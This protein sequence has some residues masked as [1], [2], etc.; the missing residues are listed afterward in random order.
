MF[1]WAKIDSSHIADR[2]KSKGAV[3]N[4]RLFI[5]RRESEEV[6]IGKNKTTT[7]QAGYYKVTFF[8]GMA[9]VYQKDYLTHVDQ[10]NIDWIS[11]RFLMSGLKTFS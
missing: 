9:G 10:Q 2:R 7:N 3:Q 11:G 1:F 8:Q 6:K 5:G 4:E